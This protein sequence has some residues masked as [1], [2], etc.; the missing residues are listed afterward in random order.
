MRKGLC[1]RMLF[2]ME[3]LLVSNANWGLFLVNFI[4]EVLI[5]RHSGKNTHFLLFF[6]NL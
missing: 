4:S 2:L 6:Y 3:V 1:Q 5:Q